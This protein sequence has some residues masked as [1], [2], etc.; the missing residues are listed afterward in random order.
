MSGTVKL[1]LAALLLSLLLVV[2]ISPWPVGP[3]GVESFQAIGEALFGRYALSFEI[4]A[5]LL[6]AA[7]VGALLLAR[8]E[9]P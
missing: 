8:K 4:L 3:T 7:M 1:V 2:L 9:G 5:V 6:L